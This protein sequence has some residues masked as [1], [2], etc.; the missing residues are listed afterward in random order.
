MTSEWSGGKIWRLE[1]CERLAGEEL[2]RLQQEH[3]KICIAR[4]K[5]DIS[6]S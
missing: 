2:E 4:T 1:E 5:C 3:D 6:A